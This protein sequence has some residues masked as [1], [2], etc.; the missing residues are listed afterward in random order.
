MDVLLDL[1]GFVLIALLLGLLA[2][3][4]F[5]EDAAVLTIFIGIPLGLFAEAALD[6]N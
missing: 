3:V 1:P 6:S 4:F 2:L 5:G